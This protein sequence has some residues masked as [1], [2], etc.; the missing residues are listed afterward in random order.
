MKKLYTNEPNLTPTLTPTPENDIPIEDINYY[1]F[2]VYP[3]DKKDNHNNTPQNTN[4][5]KDNDTKEPEIRFSIQSFLDD[6]IEPVQ[7]EETDM[8]SCMNI[9]SMINEI[10]CPDDV[11]KEYSILEDDYLEK[12]ILPK[13][14]LQDFNK[15]LKQYNKNYFINF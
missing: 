1:S 3:E 5:G 4:L 12:R 14:S 10:H 2:V 15:I 9:M 7:N 11:K 8:M 6:R 13:V